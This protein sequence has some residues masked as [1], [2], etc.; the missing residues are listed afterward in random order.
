MFPRFRTDFSGRFQQQ[1]TD[2]PYAA[3]AAF[4]RLID[5]QICATS[6][7]F[8]QGIASDCRHLLQEREIVGILT[9][10][11]APSGRRSKFGAAERTPIGKTC[12][13]LAAVA[14]A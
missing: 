6:G 13:C 11:C 3:T 10:C 1:M 9:A 2:T 4:G 8:P 5:R 7:E 14:V 12:F